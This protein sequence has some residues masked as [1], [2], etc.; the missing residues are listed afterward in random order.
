[1][2]PIRDE[3]EDISVLESEL[4]SQMD[5]DTFDFTSEAQVAPIG[6]KLYPLEYMAWMD[7][8]EAYRK[9]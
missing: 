7:P 3:L 5:E 8:T 2:P 9:H 6:T 1:M 4:Y